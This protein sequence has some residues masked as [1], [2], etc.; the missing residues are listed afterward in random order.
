MQPGV[1][2]YRRTLRPV[3]SLLRVLLLHGDGDFE[4]LACPT[5]A[6]AD[7]GGGVACVEAGGE[8]HVAIGGTD[9]VGDIE[10]DP[11]ERVDPGLR[12][13]VVRICGLCVVHEQVTR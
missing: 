3:V 11:A 8:T 10:C 12:P 5:P 1:P 9:P 7:D 6:R 4:L 2:G 13:G